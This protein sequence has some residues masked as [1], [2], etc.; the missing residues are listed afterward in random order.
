MSS[1]TPAEKA[2]TIRADCS[3][4]FGSSSMSRKMPQSLR[5]DNFEPAPPN[6]ARKLAVLRGQW[7]NRLGL[8]NERLSPVQAAVHA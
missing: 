3:Q 1:L 5:L 4:G 6:S 8:F 2:S 7:E